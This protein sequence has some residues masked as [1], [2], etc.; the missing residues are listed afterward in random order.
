MNVALIGMPGSGKSFVGKKLAGQL[1]YE[2]IE[3]DKVL[4]QKYDLPLQQVVEMLGTQSF[5]DKEAEITIE[6]TSDRD[7]LVISPG[8]SVIYRTSAMEYLKKVSTLIY[9]QVSLDVI[10]ERIGNTPRGIVNIDNKNLAELYAE[11]TPLYE[12][13]ADYTVNGDYDAKVVAADILN[14]IRE[15]RPRQPIPAGEK[16]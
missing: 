10:K 13:W 4:E 15:H 12:K 8:G 16:R 7:N 1:G 9:L 3:L 6:Q 14:A 2:F 5:L 11:R